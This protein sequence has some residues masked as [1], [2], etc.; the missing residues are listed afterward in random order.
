MKKKII[1]SILVVFLAG[2]T[3][4]AFYINSLL[5]IITGYAAKNLASAVFISGRDQADVE[6]LDLNFSV[7][8]YTSN[9][10]DT[11]QKKV[12]SRFLWGKSTAIYRDGFGCTI[13]HGDEEETLQR[14]VFPSGTK[15]DYN[16]DSVS[17]PLGDILPGKI[18]F[19]IDLARLGQIADNLIG[20]DAYNGH[21]FAFVVMHKGIPVIEKYRPEFNQKTRFLSWSM[22]KS[23]TNAL[24]GILV[25]DGK[26][27]INKP[28]DIPEWQNDDR[29]SISINNL[30]QMQSGLKW[31]EDYG[32]GSDVNLMLHRESDFAAYVAG[33][34]L[35]SAPGSEWYYSSGSTNLV[36]G[37]IRK[38]INNDDEYFRLAPERLFNRIGMPD[39]VFEA[40]AS[41]TLVGS[42]YIYATT[43]DYA[44]FALLYLQDGIFNGERILPEG[45]VKYTTTPVSGSDGAYGSSFW[46]NGNKEFPDAPANMFYC[47]GHDGQRIFILPEQQMAVVILGYSPKPDHVMDFNSLLRDILSA[48]R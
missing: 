32:S 30:L 18:I 1:Y 5:P 37:L 16:Q 19:G 12:T 14:V 41:G 35:K 33:H 11:I 23:F 29:K 27:D 45:W 43:R 6:A 38:A 15:P 21:A 4:G 13:V 39:A 22:A 8:R 42:S 25:Q 10:V 46:L 17:W 31:N 26:L 20:K 36:S 7:I 9:E 40:D 47:K 34:Q 44:R 3:V 24:A 28:A 2:L 48:V